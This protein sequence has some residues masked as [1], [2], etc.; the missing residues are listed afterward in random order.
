MAPVLCTKV[1]SV[2]CASRST[3]RQA[4]TLRNVVSSGRRHS[5]CVSRKFGTVSDTPRNV[6]GVI[7]G[8]GVTGCSLLYH[9]AKKGL[10][11]ALFEKSEL[12]SGATWH[13]AGLVTN[14][15]SGNNF[16][17]WHTEGVRTFTHWQEDL[18]LP[19]SFHTP[20]SIRL[21]P[22]Q[23]DYIDEAKH[24]LAKAQL[25]EQLFGGPPMEMISPDE[26][27]KLHPL[28]N[29]GADTNIYAGL[30]T[31][32]DGHID[33]TSVTNVFAE[34]AKEAGGRLHRFAE[35]V[36][37]NLL[38]DRRWE[39][40]VQDKSPDGGGDET[41]VIA[42]FVINAGGLWCDRVGHM[43]NVHIPAV[44]LQHQ[45]VITETIDA[46]KAAHDANGGKQL[47]VLR[48]LQGSFYL[49]DE[50][51]GFLVGPYEGQ[52]SVVLSPNEWRHEGMPL[53][54]S[55][56]LFDGDTDRLMP[57]LERAMEI[58][59]SIGEV[60]MATVLNGPTCWPADGNHLV[61]PCPEWDIAPNYWLACAESYGIAHSIGLGR[62]LSEWIVAGEPP[63]ELTET[64]PARYGRWATKDWV[65][66]KVKEAY[67]M[68]NHVHFPNENTFAARPAHLKNE[69]IYK[70]L[71]GK[72]C[73]FGFHHGWEGPNFFIP[74]KAGVQVGNAFGSFRRPDCKSYIKQECQGLFDFG[75]ICYWP[76]AKYAVKGP[77]A[78][79]FLDYMVANRIPKVGRCQLCH[80][81]TPS[82][83]VY[84]EITVARVS[85]D[86]FYLVSYPEMEMHDWRWMQMH[87]PQDGSVTIDNITDLYGTLMV[88]GPQSLASL[89]KL[90]PD[91]DWKLKFYENKEVEVI[92][93]VVARA[94]KVSFTGEEGLELHIPLKSVGQVY[95]A[96]MSAEPRLCDWGGIAMGSFRLEK[97]IK[98]AGKDFTKDHNALEAGLERFCRMDEKDFIGRDTLLK[99]R[100]E[101]KAEHGGRAPQCSV[102][103]E[104]AAPDG[105]DCT[106]NEPLIDK[107]SQKIAGFVTSGGYGYLVERSIAMGYV[108]REYL[109][110]PL[111]VQ[112]LGDTYDVSIRAEPHML[113]AAQRAKKAK[114]AQAVA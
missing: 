11:V 77:G 26:I 35:V 112:L 96:L 104:V 14:Y 21:I 62:Y 93:G 49:R 23:A 27:Q 102:L 22:N 94:L 24:Q 76:F 109:D 71:E 86:E 97:G 30:M 52:D 28:C 69:A 103:L 70:I 53:N 42:D 4:V 43:A 105:I 89:Q 80:F 88:N 92:P 82:G 59:P 84:S 8:G 60:G 38:P 37:L 34:K 47:P 100:D 20:G 73:Q 75:G 58:V 68:N 10:D 67:G 63:Y 19:L 107:A 55:N 36:R 99:L 48:D 78:A 29:V 1:P 111:A 18:G 114:A 57:H 110:K 74:E 7:V 98:A 16:R 3:S 50:H 40:V 64:D 9:L 45:Y 2:I 54:L 31:F 39:V 79:A 12:A 56:F 25:Y 108:R 81:L 83:K 61:G 65:G 33:P 44:V 66:E 91:I 72:G 51:H 87:V 85:E 17:F 13:A 41:T 32:G 113:M 6:T 101:Y 90:A 46:L 95:E 106:G 15:H 5:S